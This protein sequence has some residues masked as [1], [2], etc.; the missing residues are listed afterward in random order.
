MTH[1]SSVPASLVA[2]DALNEAA[3]EE[4]ER[5]D[6]ALYRAQIDEPADFTPDEIAA[7]ALLVDAAARRVRL[8]RSRVD[9]SAHA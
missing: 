6:A 2:S 3:L 1:F 7:M 5:F 9:R 8:A 4:A